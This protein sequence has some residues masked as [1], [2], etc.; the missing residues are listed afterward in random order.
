MDYVFETSEEMIERRY[1]V[2]ICYDIYDNKRRRNFVKCE[3]SKNKY[4]DLISKVVYHIAD[5]D[6]VRVYRISGNGEVK[7]W[8]N[9]DIPEVEEVIII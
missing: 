5:E 3:L 1:F 7:T 4:E 6:N 9:V 8:G 2:V